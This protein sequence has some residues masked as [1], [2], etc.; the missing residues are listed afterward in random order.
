[1]S[2]STPTDQ[3]YSTVGAV[4][5]DANG[6]LAAGTSTGGLTNKRWGRVGDV[7]VIGAGTYANNAN[8][9]VSATGHGEYFIRSV[10][11]YD[12][13][14]LMDYQGLSLAQ[15]AQRVVQKKLVDRGGSGGVI[16]LDPRGNIAL[17]FNTSGMY[18]AAIDAQGQLRVG[19]YQQTRQLDSGALVEE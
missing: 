16:A 9:A 18:R 5:L 17:E 10:V 11:A 12:I 3:I 19:I 13:C 14:A 2:Q 7:P 8:C 15:A 1:M 4:A 6:N